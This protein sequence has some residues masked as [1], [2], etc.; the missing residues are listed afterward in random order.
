MAN[1]IDCTT[2]SEPFYCPA[3]SINPKKCPPGYK[4]STDRQSCELCPKGSYCWP[5]ASGQ[6]C[7]GALDTL[8]S[9]ADTTLLEGIAGECDAL[10]G[11]V[12]RY[13]AYSKQPIY[14]GFEL[15]EAGSV[16]FQS[17][18]GPI[19]RGYILDDANAGE[20]KACA[21]GEYQP[22]F[23]GTSCIEC[24]KGR[25]CDEEALDDVQ[26]KLCDSGYYCRLGNT[27]ANPTDELDLASDGTY[28][29][30]SCSSGSY[31]SGA[32]IHEQDCPDGFISEEEGLS[33]CEACPVGYFCNKD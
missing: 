14:E 1:G 16:A 26:P 3:G 4:I 6:Y 23:F 31:C 10:E 19:I 27:M 9:G 8:S 28:K 33:I 32:L 2:A 30:K 12:C 20:L 17:Y 21:I 15:I 25:Y 18:S 7:G 29:G 5:C 22:S 11:F 13:G 24:M